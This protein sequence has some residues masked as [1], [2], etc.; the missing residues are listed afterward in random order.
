MTPLTLVKLINGTYPLLRNF[1]ISSFFSLFVCF[2]VWGEGD[3]GGKG[4]KK[5]G[6]GV[7][8]S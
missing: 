2:V 5:G 4:N 1:F 3:G 7:C 6:N 8:E